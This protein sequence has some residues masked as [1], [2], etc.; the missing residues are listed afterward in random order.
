MEWRYNFAMVQFLFNW[1]LFSIYIQV[2]VSLYPQEEY[3]V[4]DEPA[5]GGEQLDEGVQLAVTNRPLHN[6]RR[7][8]RLESVCWDN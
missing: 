1:F 8:Y 6:L 2:W 3:V 7:G 5:E 4:V